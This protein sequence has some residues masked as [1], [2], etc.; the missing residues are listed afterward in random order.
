DLWMKI[1]TT[2]RR[3]NLWDESIASYKKVMR[4]E[5]ENLMAVNVLL[6]TL[7]NTGDWEDALVLVDDMLK[8]DLG[9]DGVFSARKAMIVTRWLG[10]IDQASELLH[11]HE[12]SSDLLQIF[13]L[14]ANRF[15][16]HDLNGL[17]ADFEKPEVK[18][19]L[20]SLTVWTANPLF[21]IGE[22]HA[23]LGDFTDAL[24][25]LQRAETDLQQ[26]IKETNP[27][28]LYAQP[29]HYSSLAIIQAYL[30][31]EEKSLT[32]MR[33]SMQLL[34]LSRD[35][36]FGTGILVSSARTLTILGKQDEAIDQLEHL[37]KL[38]AGLTIW[39]LRLHPQWDPLRE[40]PRFQ[41]LVARD[42][43]TQL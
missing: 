32:A 25:Y 6:E 15:Y 41:E 22:A 3:L 5:P 35:Y 8:S 27:S 33:R 26:Q 19:L 1:G 11:E 38:P 21:A 24:P 2:Q 29:F 14:L 36:L 42:P 13:A 34:P 23:V 18:F 43:L 9:D 12:L 16:Q 40:N 20:E 7:N 37:V 4:F 17:L 28:N 31:K 30:G 39:E 10:D